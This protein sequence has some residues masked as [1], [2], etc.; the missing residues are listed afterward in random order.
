MPSCWMYCTRQ[1]DTRVTIPQISNSNYC[2]I[3]GVSVHGSVSRDWPGDPLVGRKAWIAGTR[4]WSSQLHVDGNT[5]LMDQSAYEGIGRWVDALKVILCSADW[6]I[7]VMATEASSA[8][9]ILNTCR[10]LSL[11]EAPTA[12]ETAAPAWKHDSIIQRQC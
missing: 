3:L 9:T 5:H 10:G 8:V 2:L 6:T 1:F 12:L 11:P 7:D 4:P